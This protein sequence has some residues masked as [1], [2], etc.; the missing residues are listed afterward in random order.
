MS[1]RI[2]VLLAAIQTAISGQAPARGLRLEELEKMALESNPAIRAAAAGVEAARGRRLQAGLYPNPVIGGTGDEIAGGPVIRYGEWGGFVEQRIVTAGKRGVSRQI[3]GQEVAQA[4]TAAEAERL[5][6]L[7]M[8]RTLYYEALGDQ[9]LVELRGELA[10]VSQR[11]VGISR[12]LANLGQADRPDV[13]A[14]EIEGQRAELALQMAQNARDR[15]WRQLAAVTNNASLAPRPLEGDLE[16]APQLDREALR[17][18]IEQ[19]SPEVR[20]AQ[21]GIARAELVLRQARIASIPDVVARGGLRYNRELLELNRRPVGLEGFFDI[22]VEIPLFNRNQGNIAAARADQERARR[23]AERVRL[24]LRSR[25]AAVYREH[26]D[27][28]H[29]LERY[30]DQIIPRARQAHELYQNSFRQMAASYPQVLIAQR[31]LFQLREE[32]VMALVGAWRSAV[33]IQGLL[34]SSGAEMQ[35]MAPAHAAH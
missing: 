2:V 10:A 35:A 28:V 6:V 8:V 27:A 15:T 22:G 12:E 7:S 9:R 33:E 20:E 17:V 16:P 14:A 23:E 3:A 34:V 18:R 26:Q 4:E 13:L 5:R 1:R 29:T 24:S 31:S 25:L 32:Y 19:E 21:T 30:R 11:A